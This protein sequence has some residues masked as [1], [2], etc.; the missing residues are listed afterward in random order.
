MGS[1]IDTCFYVVYTEE[2]G[3]E[4]YNKIQMGGSQPYCAILAND[5]KV[6][7]IGDNN[8]RILYYNIVDEENLLKPFFAR[9]A[10]FSQCVTCIVA[11]DS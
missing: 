2:N 8:N 4:V 5:D 3:D 9:K 7:M 11:L 10:N 1:Q 6:L